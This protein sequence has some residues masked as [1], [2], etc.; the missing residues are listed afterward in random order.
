M[1]G[2]AIYGR[3]WRLF[4]GYTLMPMPSALKPPDNCHSSAGKA[5]CYKEW[6]FVQVADPAAIR[7]L[8]HSA[9]AKAVG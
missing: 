2:Q 6:P 4:D 3:N 8:P 5:L 7:R 1:Y 9:V